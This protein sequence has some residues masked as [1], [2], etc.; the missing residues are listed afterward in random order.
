[1]DPGNLV[2]LTF[3]DVLPAEERMTIGTQCWGGGIKADK[4][5]Q[6]PRG[7]NY[8]MQQRLSEELVQG[9]SGCSYCV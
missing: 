2:E 3:K 8:S 9:C 7:S 1:M 5:L 6:Q 4:R